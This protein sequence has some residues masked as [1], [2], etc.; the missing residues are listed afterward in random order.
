MS[1]QTVQGTIAN[2]ASL[3]PQ[4]NFGNR[5]L[6]GI[7]MPATW[8]AAGLTFQV[9]PD[10]GTTWLELYTS[11]GAEQTFTV[12][13]SQFIAVDP[14]TWRGINCIKARSG[15]AGAPVN[16][17]QNSTLTFILA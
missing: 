6:V 8:T 9:S 5:L 15:P 12:A 14:T 2:G 11:A 3:S 10:G 1:L 16:Q 4:I 17:S 13:A 7:Q